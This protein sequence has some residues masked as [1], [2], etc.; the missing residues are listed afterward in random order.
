[1]RNDDDA[2]TT[3]RA[4]ERQGTTVRSR[5]RAFARSFARFVRVEVCRA[6]ARV[7]SL[8]ST[9][10]RRR[11]RTRGRARRT[12]AMNM[13][14]GKFR[15]TMHSLNYGTVMEAAARNYMEEKTRE[16]AHAK[17]RARAR[18]LDAKELCEVRD[19]ARA[20]GCECDRAGRDATDARR[21][22]RRQTR[23]GS[24]RVVA[25]RGQED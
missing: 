1:M 17:A 25:T 22:W 23:G 12:S 5:V 11:G 6:R 14:G 8:K 18:V 4:T 2:T 7:K 24:G 16:D 15:D 21:D 3:S 13:D 10:A 19:D 9:I 20:R